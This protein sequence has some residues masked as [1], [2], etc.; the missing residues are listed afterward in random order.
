MNKFGAHVCGAVILNAN[1]VISAAHCVSSGSASGVTLI[2]G[3]HVRSNP[4]GSEQRSNVLKIINHESYSTPKRFS[5][6][7]SLL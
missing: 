7:I 3:A 2:A 4:L 6:D 1:W 5:N